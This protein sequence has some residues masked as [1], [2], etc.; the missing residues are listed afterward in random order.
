[1]GDGVAATFAFYMK[2]MEARVLRRCLRPGLAS[3]FAVV[4]D[5]RGDVGACREAL[6][7]ALGARAGK[8][9][10]V[11]ELERS[12]E[13]SIGLARGARTR[14]K[15]LSA[16]PVARNEVRAVN[17]VL[18]LVPPGW[19]SIRLAAEEDDPLHHDRLDRDPARLARVTSRVDERG[20][21]FFRE[22]HRCSRCHRA[23]VSR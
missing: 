18:A 12:F 4:D 20:E 2:G 13:A 17:E 19:R 5:A 9:E 7:A 10:A 14:A 8:G 16:A 21:G 1:M 23:K 3:A 15:Q 11:L 6:V 22:G